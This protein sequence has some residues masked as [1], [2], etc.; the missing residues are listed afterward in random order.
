MILRVLA[1]ILLLLGAERPVLAAPPWRLGDPE[2]VWRLAPPADGPTATI[3]TLALHPD[4]GFIVVVWIPPEGFRIHRFRADWTES[5]RRDLP[6]PTMPPIHGAQF[7]HVA[8]LPSGHIA[9]ALGG[10][11]ALLAPEGGLAWVNVGDGDLFGFERF[12]AIV[13]LAGGLLVGGHGV[14]EEETPCWGI[15]GMVA[16]VG[17]EGR[18][19][20]RAAYRVARPR[21]AFD[22]SGTPFHAMPLMARRGGGALAY[23]DSSGLWSA[24]GATV[25]RWPPPVGGRCRRGGGDRVLE[26]DARGSVRSFGP[27]GDAL[28]SLRRRYRDLPRYILVEAAL[29]VPG[30]WALADPS[31]LW[32][33][34]ESW[35]VYDAVASALRY[36][37]DEPPDARRPRRPAV[38]IVPAVAAASIG[39]ATLVLL[40]KR[41]G[42]APERSSLYVLM[43][44]TRGR[45]TVAA[46]RF[47]EP[48]RSVRLVP[49]AGI[50][51][52]LAE[53]AVIRFTLR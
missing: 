25:D 4:G 51:Y 14:S 1:L 5:W 35:A 28:A 52:G 6:V 10:A 12:G 50:A 48:L 22:W 36:E 19:V 34:P 8:V 49:T 41:Y 30:Q 32:L 43:Q 13:P 45:A 53:N 20:W 26:I 46:E 21:G 23:V 40:R 9:L 42:P 37:R 2:V 31:L 27:E 11:L 3:G 15:Q 44:V 17:L 29:S 33:G 7:V 24:L 39:D 38:T 16:R 47:M 18:V